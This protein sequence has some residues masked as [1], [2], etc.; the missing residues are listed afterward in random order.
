MF[1]ERLLDQLTS[2]SA[3]LR[4]AAYRE[5]PAINQSYLKSIVE[6]RKYPKKDNAGVFL[7]GS[8]VD[9][10]ITLTEEEFYHQYYLSTVTKR[11]SAMYLQIIE[12]LELT[13]GTDQLPNALGNADA[14]WE[15][16]KS[17]STLNWGKDT[18]FNKV[19]D[20]CT[21]YIQ[22]LRNAGE[23]TIITQEELDK[24]IVLS[25]LIK[26]YRYYNDLLNAGEVIYQMPYLFTYQGVIC[27]ILPDML[28]FMPNNII[29]P[30]E[31]KQTDGSFDYYPK[32]AKSLKYAFQQAFYYEGL[33]NVFQDHH[34]A[35]PIQIIVSDY[36]DEPCV[37]QLTISDLDLRIGKFG[38][39]KENIVKIQNDEY[40]LKNTIEHGFHDAI[41]LYKKTLEFNTTNINFALTQGEHFGIY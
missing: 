24:S 1:D 21:E 5:I 36:G 8:M 35:N 26:S 16:F 30:I 12:Y 11:P 23:K 27:K 18:I 34:I 31:F 25:D 7:K 17:V 41:D 6:V 20:E 37:F 33:A 9:A 38:Y 13:Y 22:E 28:V 32:I 10:H 2:F 40:Q 4:F 29:Q 3:A 19:T 15:A 14:V 39:T